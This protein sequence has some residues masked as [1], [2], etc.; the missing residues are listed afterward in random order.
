MLRWHRDLPGGRLA[1][2]PAV[3]QGD[4][5]RLRV[6]GFDHLRQERWFCG[7][8]RGVRKKPFLADDDTI[9]SG[10]RGPRP[11]QFHH[12]RPGYF[13]VARQLHVIPL[14]LHQVHRSAVG[15]SRRPIPGF[16]DHPNAVDPQADAAGIERR[17]DIG[18]RLGRQHLSVPL[19]LDVGG[20]D[21]FL[22]GE[23]APIEVHRGIDAIGDAL[24]VFNVFAPQSGA[25]LPHDQAHGSRR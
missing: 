24:A 17:E 6:R 15:P 7:P 2:V 4:D 23:R 5:Q 19:D 11:F 9:F 8:G 13:L 3:G 22:R 14:P 10:E 20:I 21:L 25:W 18:A 1:A 12:R 16:V